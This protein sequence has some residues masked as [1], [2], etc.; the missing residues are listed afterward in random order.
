MTDSECTALVSFPAPFRHPATAWAREPWRTLKRFSGAAARNGSQRSPRRSDAI[1]TA[2]CRTRGGSTERLRVS[3]SESKAS[4]TTQSIASR[5]LW[6][7]AIFLTLRPFAIQLEGLDPAA[8]VQQLGRP[9]D[10]YL[11]IVVT[12]A[13]IP[14]LV[15]K[16]REVGRIVATNPLL[17][18]F[19]FL[20]YLSFEWSIEP[21][22]T[23]RMSGEL[24]CV[25]TIIAVAAASC[26]TNEFITRIL[27]ALILAVS[28]S[29]I[30]AIALPIYG[31]QHA[32]IDSHYSRWRGIF[33]HKNH[34]G[35]IAATA[36][37]AL[38]TCGPTLLRRRTWVVGSAV[39]FLCVMMS[40]SGSG[41]VLSV[42]GIASYV[43]I[44]RFNRVLKIISVF[45]VAI[46][47]P[48]ILT[49]GQDS[50]ALFTG[51]LGRDESFTGRTNLWVVGIKLWQERPIGGHGLAAFSS[52]Y[53]TD[54]FA[55]A[56]A[57]GGHS[58]VHDPHNAFLFLSIALGAVGVLTLVA[59]IVVALVRS[60]R[61]VI[62]EG[63]SSARQLPIL[64]LL[65]WLAAG[66]VESAPFWPGTPEFTLGILGLV[67]ACLARPP[68]RPITVAAR[69]VKVEARKRRP[70]GTP[71]PSGAA[72][73]KY[74]R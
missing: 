45:V 49:Y 55:N 42:V 29:V 24:T 35:M 54:V 33:V 19:L 38:S 8:P 28:L 71:P 69:R 31:V 48:I 52:Q 65:L 62:V 23:L 40:R 18:A 12:L 67:T 27:F 66:L 39:A 56:A 30:Y 10:F 14:I 9:Y 7:G 26:D 3:V 11:L 47:I 43:I 61:L 51:L 53:L 6:V 37:V 74:Y 4:N 2:C 68:P 1:N 46:I 16:A 72:G 50:L 25:L 57:E 34:L 15:S 20:G 21:Y 58:A 60:V 59:A 73:Q 13:T 36:F 32:D 5:W 64:L 63:S 44:F 41:I 22:L 17:L 70:P